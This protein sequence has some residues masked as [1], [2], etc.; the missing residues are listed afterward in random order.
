MMIRRAD[1]RQRTE[2]ADQASIRL[3]YTFQTIAEFWNAWTPRADKNGS[4][5]TIAE[6]DRLARLI[7]LLPYSRETH[8]PITNLQPQISSHS[9]H[10]S[11][12]HLARY[13]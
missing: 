8:E 9:S 4:G 10:F 6:S 3:C 13:A 5:L 11:L 2:S 7:E 12:T 1:H